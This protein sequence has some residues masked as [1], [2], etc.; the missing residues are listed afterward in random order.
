MT[1]AYPLRDAPAQWLVRRTWDL[2]VE[3]S[4]PGRCIHVMFLGKI[5]YSQE[6]TCDALVSHRG[7][8]GMLRK[9]EII[10]GTDDPSARPITIE[11]QFTFTDNPHTN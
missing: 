7:E 10:V 2:E 5:L 9:L 1:T 6:V 11:G 3:N 8:E 4:S